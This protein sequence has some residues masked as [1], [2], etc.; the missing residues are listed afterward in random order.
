MKKIE[1]CVFCGF[2]HCD[3]QLR[4]IG[5]PHKQHKLHFHDDR[6][7]CVSEVK[8]E[9]LLM[10]AC[11]EH[12]PDGIARWAKA[13]LNDTPAVYLTNPKTLYNARYADM[14]L[15]EQAWHNWHCLCVYMKETRG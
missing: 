12:F 13:R 6:K 2:V 11:A 7:F 5:K 1:I 4:D 15:S 8:D 3:D 9:W 14:P 10:T